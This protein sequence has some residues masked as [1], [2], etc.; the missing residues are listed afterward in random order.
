MNLRYVKLGLVGSIALFFSLVAFDNLIEYT[1]NFPAVQHVLSMDTTFDVP[2]LKRR[3][4][5]NPSIQLGIYYLIIASELLTAILCWLG[6]FRLLSKINASDTEFNSSKNVAI[7]GLF[8]GFILYMVG[9]I[10]IGGE[11]FCMWQS[12]TWNAQP[13]A[14]LFAGLIMLVMIFLALP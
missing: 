2:I 9:F 5:T 7:I 14:G 12:P 3:A 13:A 10:V 1:S 6:C 8:L 11:W 4:I